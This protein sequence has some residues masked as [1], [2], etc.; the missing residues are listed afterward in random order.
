MQVQ[1]TLVS[2]ESKSGESA[3]GPWTRH[4]YTDAANTKFQTFDQNLSNIAYGLLNQPVIVTYELKQNGQY[5]N[6]DITSVTPAGAAVTGTV[7]QA[8]PQQ[9]AP[10]AVAPT[11]TPDQRSPKIARGAGLKS[12]LV[13]YELGLV[14]KASGTEVGLA[15]IIR[16]ADKFASY[17]E[18]GASA[19]IAT[20][21][22][23][24]AQPV[25]QATPPPAP[26]GDAVAGAPAPAQPAPA[27]PVV[28]PQGPTDDI[29]FMPTIHGGL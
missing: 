9:T 20:E 23:G 7:A 22:A 10:A 28:A 6:N 17:I 27:Q 2:H 11:S 1:T 26:G 8:A 3:R 29:P 25:Q 13:A 14:K 16:L 21:T 18:N 19:V 12:A 15:D 5:T 4:T 24:A